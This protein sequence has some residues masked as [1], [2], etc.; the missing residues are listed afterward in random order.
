[1]AE[2]KKDENIYDRIRREAKE[3]EQQK[4]EREDRLND[5]VKR[6]QL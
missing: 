3:R 1:M 6:G 5:Q 2:E 4:R